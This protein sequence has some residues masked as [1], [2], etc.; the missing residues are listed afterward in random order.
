MSANWETA[1]VLQAGT[2]VSASGAGAAV[3]LGTRDRLL[4]QVLN[5]TAISAGASL[6]VRLEVSPD[7]TTAWR[8]LD[9]FATRTSVGAERRTFISPERYVRVAYTITGGGPSVTFDV[10]GA[11]GIVYA[12]LDDLDQHG[13]PAP[14]LAKRTSHQKCEA[15]AAASTEADGK[16]ALAF[17]LPLEAWSLDLTKAVC[18]IAAYEELSVRGFNPDGSDA[19]VRDRRND[20]WKWLDS[21]ARG[22]TIPVGIV[23]STP[24]VEDD[25]I[26]VV[27]HEARGWR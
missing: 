2:A 12:N 25:G 15:L 24:E 23:D 7:G 27:T 9:V 11:A 3:D 14:S 13:V 26:V 20:A 1:K 21:V 6:A 18:K 19:N 10:S 4:R 17:D 8:T 5:V 22:E 16:L